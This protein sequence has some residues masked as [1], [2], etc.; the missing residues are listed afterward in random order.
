MKDFLLK[1]WAKNGGA[2][3][4]WQRIYGAKCSSK[5]QS[6]NKQNKFFLKLYKRSMNP[7]AGL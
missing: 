7:R 3:F 5:D 6:R 1:I 4:T 2:H